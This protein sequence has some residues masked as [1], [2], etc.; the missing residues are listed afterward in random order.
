MREGRR[1]N[2]RVR[3]RERESSA[4]GGGL[5]ALKPDSWMLCYRTMGGCIDTSYQKQPQQQQSN[6]F[7]LWI[8]G[9]AR[10]EAEADQ[11]GDTR[12]VTVPRPEP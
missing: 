3:K 10:A 12:G 9:V 6:P 8:P 1:E 11:S 5:R 4:P 2:E 7:R